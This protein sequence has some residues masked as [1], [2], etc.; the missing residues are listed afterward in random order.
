MR[1]PNLQTRHQH[2]RRNWVQFFRRTVPDVVWQRLAQDHPAPRA[3]RVRW[4]STYLILAW[5]VIGWSVRNTLME[6]MAEARRWL[7][8]RFPAR[9]RPGNTYPGLIQATRRTGP[10][11]FH[12]FWRHLRLH[13]VGRLGHART[14]HGWTVLAADGSR[15][16]A[17]RTRANAR[18]LPCA[19]RTHTGPQWW[20][21][22]LVH[23]PTLLVWD[24]RQ[25]PGTSSERGHLQEMIADLPPDTLLVA[26]AGYVGFDLMRRLVEA[27]VD[28]LIRCG[29]NVRLR[30]EG[31]HS[32]IERDSQHR[33][34]YLW[35]MNRRHAPPRV[36][37]L[38][39]LKRRGR[40]VYLLTNVQEETRL[41]RR[42]ASEIYQARW[43][44]EVQFRSL[45][46]TLAH[47][48]VLSKTPEAGAMEL[49]AYVLA[50]A[51]LMLEGAVALGRQVVRLSVAA[52]LRVL[53][54]AL[55]AL[56]NR[57]WAAPVAT[58]LRAALRDE[59]TR[60]RPKRSRHWPRKKNDHPPGPPKLQSLTLREKARMTAITRTFSKILG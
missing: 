14:W 23:L 5:A 31:A 13:A 3:R 59:Y 25:G 60:R 33:Y 15:F 11:L 9:R 8:G 48:R 10:G 21:T 16:D 18:R 58:A 36:L 57:S 1:I 38:I 7:V 37:R 12:D 54:G 45:K 4:G 22:W 49:A 55:E 28:F 53:R 20:V 30:V 56:R 24:W 34:V 41:S 50:L 2:Y 6:R 27:K 47:Y 19:G 46:R 51:L 29:S 44:V 39:E 35:P 26:D 42:M 17:P 43:G 40:R 32:R 52:A